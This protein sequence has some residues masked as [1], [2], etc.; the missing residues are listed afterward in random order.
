M[1][2]NDSLKAIKRFE[3]AINFL[4][5]RR[6]FVHQILGMMRKTPSA[7]V[8]T[9]SVRVTDDGRFD[10][11]YNVEWVDSLKDEELT[12][13][14][15]HE[16]LHLVL[17]HCTSRRFDNYELGNIAYDLAVNELIH[18]DDGCKIPRDKN[19]KLI[20]CHVSEFKKE[21]IYKDIEERQSAE[22]YYEFLKKRTPQVQI[23]IEMPGNEKNDLKNSPRSKSE[24]KDGDNLKNN[25]NLS[26]D[27]KSGK[28]SKS[29]EKIENK[30]IKIK[31]RMLDGHDDW[32][33]NEIADERVR[34]KIIEIDRNEMWGDIP[35]F[36]KEQILAAQTRKINWKPFIRQFCGNI[37][38]NDREST[39][40]R[41]NRRTGYIHPGYK[42]IHVDK[43]LAAVDSSGS[44]SSELLGQ[45]LGVI[46]TMIDFF[47]IDMCVFDHGI[48]QGPIPF[49]RKRVKFDFKGRG[50]T[51][52]QA[53]MNLAQDK[54]YKA[55]IVLTDGCAPA[56]KK[57]EGV[58][59]LWCLCNGAAAPVDWGLKVHLKEY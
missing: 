27:N 6:R 29:N 22:W 39:R 42:R 33:E 34:A 11:S 37:I 49:N 25:S 4:I 17:H 52:F 12:Y 57:P 32:K 14:L 46:N 36:D 43:V 26:G 44:I 58:R 7:H 30:N 53:V 20:G 9:M 41:P 59:V 19:G 16:I 28:S 8:P 35:G 24:K 1:A 31:V 45:F 2:E 15:N 13:V 10:L 47:P 5:I 51:D 54:K 48:E 21:K 38:W 23:Q 18:E 3:W 40:K 56:P 50:G 55:L